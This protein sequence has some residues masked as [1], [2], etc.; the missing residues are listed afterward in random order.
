MSTP[1]GYILAGTETPSELDRLRLL[2]RARDPGTVRRLEALGI[3]PGLRCLEIGAGAGSVARWMAEAVGSHGQVTACDI[4]DRFLGGLEDVDVRRLDLRSD[5]LPGSSFDLVHCRSVLMH[6]PDPQEVLARMTAALRPGGLL[7]VE[8]GDSGLFHWAGG[9]DGPAM[10]ALVHRVFRALETA[11][12]MDSRFGRRLLDLVPAPGLDVEGAEVETFASRRGEPT[13]QFERASARAVRP[14]LLAAGL[15]DGDDVALAERFF[16]YD[17][18][19]VLGATLVAV[20]A[21]R[22]G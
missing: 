14:G 5:P 15:L 11:G 4:D 18:T 3:A 8:E 19:M 2:Q 16:A 21:R 7:L 9:P 20:S 1:E 22:R 12:A 13:Y 17:E 6:L 10:T